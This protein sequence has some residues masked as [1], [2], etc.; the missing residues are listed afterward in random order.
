MECN[1][2]VQEGIIIMVHIHK[3]EIILS[4]RKKERDLLK[5]NKANSSV[6][7]VKRTERS[8][9]KP[10]RPKSKGKTKHKENKE[11]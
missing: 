11:V 5:K 3:N 10:V 8:T 1:I 7:N 4:K 6:E 2:K 9:V